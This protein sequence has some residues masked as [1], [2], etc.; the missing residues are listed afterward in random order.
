VV[1]RW[2][3]LVST[4]SAE[5]ETCTL[6]SLAKATWAWEEGQRE[7]LSRRDKQERGKGP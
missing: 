7:R 6:F 3:V 2:L 1:S 5:T 4:T